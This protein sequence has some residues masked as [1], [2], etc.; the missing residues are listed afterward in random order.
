MGYINKNR[1]R[2]L[3]KKSSETDGSKKAHCK[4]M[5]RLLQSDLESPQVFNE[6]KILDKLEWLVDRIKDHLMS[7]DIREI[8]LKRLREHLEELIIK[9][10][11][12]DKRSAEI[13]P[14]QQ[15]ISPKTGEKFLITVEDM[16]FG[17]YVKLF[18]MISKLIWLGQTVISRGKRG[19]G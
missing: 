14:D 16:I 2:Q 6:H 13:N 7:V 17:E 4:T 18:V 9:D 15:M 10:V 8:H 1:F 5:I 11:K 19:E 12:A 3:E